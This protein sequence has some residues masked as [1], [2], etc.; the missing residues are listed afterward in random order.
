[1]MLRR[2]KYTYVRTYVRTYLAREQPRPYTPDS[3]YTSS[4]YVRT[5][6]SV[7][8]LSV[9]VTSEHEIKGSSW[10]RVRDEEEKEKQKQRWQKL[11]AS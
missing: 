10:E 11:A 5:Y 4:T 2:S 7:Q 3:R 9:F 8:D 6:L 1:M